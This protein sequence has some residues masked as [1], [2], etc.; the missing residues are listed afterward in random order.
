MS[1]TKPIPGAT[2]E[3]YREMKIQGNRNTG[4]RYFREMEI[5]ERYILGNRDSA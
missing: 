4:R 5:Q 2:S 3:R 1:S